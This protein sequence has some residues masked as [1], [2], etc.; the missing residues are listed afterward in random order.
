VTVALAAAALASACGTSSA[1]AS[2]PLTTQSATSATTAQAAAAPQPS[3]LS[4]PEFGLNPQRTDATDESTGITQANVGHL[5]RITLT[6]PGTVDSSAIYLHEATVD[7]V[8][9]DLIVVTTT[10]GKTLAIDANTGKTLWTFTP[11]GY[12]SW[13]GTAQITTATPI[14][15]PEGQFIY[16]ASPNGLVHKLSVANGSEDASGA[17]PARVTLEPKHEKIAAALNIDGPYVLV[18]TGGYI[19]DIPPYQG[20]VAVID[21]ASGRVRAVFNTLCANRHRLIVPSTCSASDSAIWARAGAVVEPGGKRILVGTGNAPYNGTTNFGDS[22]LELTVPQLSLRQVFTPTNEEE[23]NENDGDLGTG[24]PALL[25]SQLVL[26]GGKDG[27]LRV[28]DLAHLD[29]HPPSSHHVLG[30]E[31]QT[32]STP[33][34]GQLI[35]QPAVSQQGGHTTAFVAESS[36]TAAYALRGSRIHKL[37]ENS[38]AGTS[39]VLAG[40]LLYVYEPSGGGINVYEPDSAHAIATLP[41]SSGHWNSPIVVDGHVIEPEGNANEHATSGTIDVF[42]VQ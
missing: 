4:W 36:G 9:H 8:A 35:T 33:G 10:Y 39:P 40:G 3:L 24:G 19:G 42:S 26:V 37:W 28:L 31:V 14:A 1:P 23:L 20:H 6:L 13:V 18:V 41:G 5:H 32:L 34:G 7:G 16:A 25:S 17:W 30:G 2:S 15:D 38:T 27:L 22:W 12:S 29:G 11:P 21:R